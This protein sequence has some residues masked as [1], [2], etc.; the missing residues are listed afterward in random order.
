MSNWPIRQR[1]RRVTAPWA[2]GALAGL[3]LFATLEGCIFDLADV[4]IAPPGG[5]GSMGGSVALGGS[6]NP[7]GSG[8]VSNGG[9]GGSDVTQCPPEQ[10]LCPDSQC[11]PIE[12][13]YGCGSSA[14][15]PCA[16]AADAVVG[17]SEAG[18]CVV[19]SCSPGRADCNGSVID[20]CEFSFGEVSP[21]PQ[22]MPVPFANIVLDGEIADWTN[23]RSYPYEAVCRDC[24]DNATARITEDGTVPP[25]SDLESYFRVAWNND[26]FFV[27]QDTFD[28]DLLDDSSLVPTC[29]DRGGDRAVCEDGLQVFLDGRQDVRQGYFNDNIRVLVGLSERIF[30]PTNGDF[31]ADRIAA[32]AKKWAPACYR[33]EVRFDWEFVTASISNPAPPGQFPPLAGQVYGFDIAVNDWDPGIA[34]PT[35]FE[36]QSQVFWLDAGPEYAQNTNGLP[37]MR[38]V[39]GPDAGAP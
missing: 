28:R 29:Q 35:L 32:K 18:E 36:R 10:K 17:C 4:V 12:P 13:M 34:D 6:G 22:E 20:G 39:G 5:G 27:V 9:T 31:G 24:L 37:L 26:F 2:A 15:Q 21:S 16:P 3:L 7:G 33:I 25:R 38:L 8:A 11:R 30:A 23:I 19:E 1:G 14:C